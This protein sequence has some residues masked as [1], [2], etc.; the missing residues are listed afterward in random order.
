[1]A[2][3]N[4]Q[5]PGSASREWLYSK[6]QQSVGLATILGKPSSAMLPG[7]PLA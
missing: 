6:T 2:L 1:M 7:F 3:Q 5:L 4:Q